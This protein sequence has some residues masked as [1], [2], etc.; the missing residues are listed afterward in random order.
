MPADLTFSHPRLPRRTMLQAGAL[1]LVGLGMNHLAGLRETTAAPSTLQPT[2]KAKSCIYIFLSG[3]L[4]QHDSFDLKPDAPDSVRGEFQ[5]IATRTPGIQICEHLPLLA[6][7]SHLW[8]LVRSLTHS[9]NDH[10]AGHHIMLTGRTD[11]P[12][13]FAPNQ[14]GPGDWPS[15]AAVAGAMLAARNNLPPAVVLPERLI[16]NTGR[17]IPGQFAGVMGRRRDPWF[18]EAS[19]FEPKAYGAYPEYEFDHQQ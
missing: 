5:P 13:G 2:G 14:P 8:S 6:Q 1:G 17:V 10:P 7:R 18:L 15:I 4:A 3:G 16:H 19:K 11:L 12:T 9:S